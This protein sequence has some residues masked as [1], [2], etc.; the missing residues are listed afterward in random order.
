MTTFEK[1]SGFELINIHVDDLRK[2]Q[3]EIEFTIESLEKEKYN[4]L[5]QNAIKAIEEILNAGF[6]Y[7]C[8]YDR[9]GDS[10]YWSELKQELVRCKEVDSPF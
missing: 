8:F 10:Y 3:A 4:K 5:F 9:N 2:M 7:E 1:I 6:D